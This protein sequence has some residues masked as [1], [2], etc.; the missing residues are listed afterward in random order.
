MV[1]K[2]TKTCPQTHIC[3]TGQ[4]CAKKGNVCMMNYGQLKFLFKKIPPM[5]L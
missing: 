4:K 3:E 1:N 2:I 5:S